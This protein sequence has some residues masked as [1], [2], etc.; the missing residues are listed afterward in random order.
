[1][2]KTQYKKTPK[3]KY[4]AA[5]LFLGIESICLKIPGLKP[6]YLGRSWAGLNISSFLVTRRAV[7]CHWQEFTVSWSCLK[8]TGSVLLLLLLSISIT[9][10]APTNVN[11]MNLGCHT[12]LCFFLE[13]NPSF[14]FRKNYGRIIWS[15]LLKLN[16]SFPCLHWPV[17]A[18]DG[19]FMVLQFS[20]LHSLPYRSLRHQMC[21]DLS[22]VYWL[23]RCLLGTCA[24]NLYL[25]RMVSVGMLQTLPLFLEL[26]KKTHVA[27]QLLPIYQKNSLILV[28]ISWQARKDGVKKMGNLFYADVVQEMIGL[29]RH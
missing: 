3:L 11:L 26:V 28:V 5:C 15:L 18:P 9:F 13:K 29:L 22:L 20:G 16:S 17:S 6:Q 23:C 19:A 24:Y 1:M 21:L 25:A 2:Q 10:L 8:G 7:E 4:K 12:R 14:T 27:G